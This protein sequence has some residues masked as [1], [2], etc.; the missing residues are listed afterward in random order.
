MIRWILDRTEQIIL[1]A[2]A[3]G[4]VIDYDDYYY[5]ILRIYY[6]SMQLISL[7]I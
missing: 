2:K 4:N 3:N 5:V 6:Y 1:S 7:A